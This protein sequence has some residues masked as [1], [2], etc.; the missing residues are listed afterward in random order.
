M[1]AEIW[2]T[3]EI[4]REWA[5]EEECLEC[6]KVPKGDSSKRHPNETLEVQPAKTQHN[7]MHTMDNMEG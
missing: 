5:K 4:Y 6:I 2:A 7:S 3:T 1:L